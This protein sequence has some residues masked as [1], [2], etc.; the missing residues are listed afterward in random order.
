MSTARFHVFLSHNSADKPAVE[1]LARRLKAEGL[2]PWFDKW[3]LIPGQPWQQALEKALDDSDSVAV[4]IGPSGFGPWQNEEMRVALAKRVSE[5][6]GDFRVIPVLLPGAVRE[7]RSRIPS[8]LLALTWVEFRKSLDEEEAYHRL[9]SGI[10]GLSPGLRPG[11]AVLEGICPYRGLKAFQ[12]EHGR[13]FFGR[14][15]QLEWILNALRPADQS[16]GVVSAREN[17]FLAIVGASGSG[18]SSLA[19]AGLIPALKNGAF[20]GSEHWPFIVIRPGQNPLESLAVGLFNV[21]AIG[22][23]F[24]DP[25]DLAARMTAEESRLHLA[26]RVALAGGDESQ[27]LVL[28]IDQFEEVFTLA[29]DDTSRSLGTDSASSVSAKSQHEINTKAFIDNLIYAAGVAGGQTVVVLT[30][31]ADFYQKCASY[32]HLAA[33]VTDHQELVG[34]MSTNELR[35]IIEKPAQ[36]VGL[37]LQPGLTELLLQEMESQTGALPLLQHALRELWKQREGNRLTVA[38]HT[39]IGGLEGALEK[40]ANE[41]YDA[42]IPP[43]QQACRRIFMRLTQPGEGSE[44]TK[45]RVPIEQLGD[46]T[47]INPIVNRLTEV[48][49]ITA[50]ESFVEVAHEA[51][52]RTWSKLRGWIESKRESIRIQH[53]ITESA[54]EWQQA[55][56][57]ADYLYQGAR[58]AEAEEWAR[59]EDADMTPAEQQFLDASLQARD[60]EKQQKAERQQREVETLTQLAKIEKQRSEELTRF[61]NKRQQQLLWALGLAV[62]AMLASGYAFFQKQLADQAFK[63]ADAATQGEIAARKLEEAAREGIENNYVADLLKRIGDTSGP[64]A[65]N[66]IKALWQIANLGR[67]PADTAIRDRLLDSQMTTLHSDRLIK[68]APQLTRAVVGL[69]P[70][71]RQK[72][73]KHIEMLVGEFNH[74]PDNAQT[75][76]Q[77]L[78][79]VRVGINLQVMDRWFIEQAIKI[80]CD[81][82]ADPDGKNLE[83]LQGELVEILNIADIQNQE[84]HALELILQVIENDDFFKMPQNISA[85]ITAVFDSGIGHQAH[86]DA[87]KRIAMQLFLSIQ[88]ALRKLFDESFQDRDILALRVLNKCF[89][90]LPKDVAVEMSQSP[91][92]SRIEKMI[93]IT[94]QQMPLHIRPVILSIARTGI[95]RIT[96]ET[97][98]DRQRA[99]IEAMKNAESAESAEDFAHWLCYLVEKKLEFGLNAGDYNTI[100]I[101]GNKVQ[102]EPV[103]SRAHLGEVITI[104]VEGIKLVARNHTETRSQ[105]GVVEVLFKKLN[106][107]FAEESALVFSEDQVEDLSRALLDMLEKDPAKN[108]TL[109]TPDFLVVIECFHFTMSRYQG[110]ET[111]LFSERKFV[112]KKHCFERL[113]TAKL[114]KVLFPI[115]RAIAILPSPLSQD[116]VQA[117]FTRCFDVLDHA[118]LLDPIERVGFAMLIISRSLPHQLAMDSQLQIAA[119]MEQTTD[120]RKLLALSLALRGMESHVKETA[121]L[122]AYDAVNR[123]YRPDE[124]QPALEYLAQAF[125]VIPTPIP[126]KMANEILKNSTTVLLNFHNNDAMR[127]IQ[128]IECVSANSTLE[129]RRE[130]MARLLETL[131]SKKFPSK[132]TPLTHALAVV[133]NSNPRE[134]IGDPRKAI[135]ICGVLR[136][137]IVDSDTYSSRLD[138]MVIDEVQGDRIGPDEMVLRDLR[139][140]WISRQVGYDLTER[141]KRKR[142]LIHALITV[143]K[144]LKSDRDLSENPL[145]Q[146]ERKALNDEEA[147]LVKQIPKW[148]RD[149]TDV[150][151]IDQLAAS[152]PILGIVGSDDHFRSV[153]DAI[154]NAKKDHGDLNLRQS[155]SR[156]VSYLVS[157]TGENRD[158][159][160]LAVLLEYLDPDLFGGI[161]EGMRR[162][163]LTAIYEESLRI[164]NVGVGRVD[165]FKMI[166]ATIANRVD[167]ASFHQLIQ[168]LDIIPGQPDVDALIELLKSPFCDKKSTQLILKMIELKMPVQEPFGGDLWKFVNDASKNGIN[169]Q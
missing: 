123:V 69:D 58:L 124:N 12:I 122:R 34:P 26:T 4:F 68:R 63:K 73:L 155:R 22:S 17:R 106:T 133:L 70:A 66:E 169:L 38:A 117:I 161:D 56:Q 18:K 134:L 2:E 152:F 53:R 33:A 120:A 23:R 30:M 41:I 24:G 10:T 45:R 162:L 65:T 85:I 29:S 61:A 118:L 151:V 130:T 138:M 49:L 103:S 115:C 87:F 132:Q 128:A 94:N 108:S 28:L 21:P 99:I 35:E 31:R 79:A 5:S 112:I 37:E 143:V 46:P 140:S 165:P 127:L 129:V 81:R 168:S 92:P 14:Q 116:E 40:Q 95:K 55:G 98:G 153:F 6:K 148:L 77:K 47:T 96:D 74:A 3:D 84:A 105:V 141:Y 100:L 54:T 16:E 144:M 166:V 91:S 80:L 164:Q 93:Q 163:V 156:A 71:N 1:E 36:L 147:E 135:Q 167:E 158:S 121:I 32:P 142:D 160:N 145:S 27:R 97:R 13:F 82:M 107:I 57:H 159:Q 119:K 39:E 62:T 67:T 50:E 8:F 109:I 88:H 42:F 43:D 114:P 76:A 111:A 60:A 7:E 64:L 90:S 9:K 78:G 52:I 86:V 20:A 131:E 59:S 75:K 83:M 25:G 139:S 48:R 136:Q 19:R 113:Q 44:D 149:E 104:L 101:D 89:D 125:R 137:A 51:L 15:A 146:R 157:S 126:D 72:L 154:L 11:Q 150:E 102:A 110:K